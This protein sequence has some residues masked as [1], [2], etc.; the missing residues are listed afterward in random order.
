MRIYYD[1]L[2]K[3]SIIHL[4][5]RLRGGGGV[6]SFCMDTKNL[7]FKYNYD[8]TDLR[9]DGTSFQRGGMMYLRPYGW[10]R[11]ALNVKTR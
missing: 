4:V 10:K 3:E 11:V 1:L 8:F 5:L 2:I 9:D 7:D 6:E